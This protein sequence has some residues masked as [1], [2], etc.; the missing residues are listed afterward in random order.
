MLVSCVLMFR[1]G[2]RELALDWFVLLE[3][4]QRFTTWRWAV[5]TQKSEKCSQ[6]FNDCEE[7]K[8]SMRHRS[9]NVTD[10]KKNYFFRYDR[11]TILWDLI[12]PLWLEWSYPL[13]GS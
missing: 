11:P 9:L 1:V 10:S 12:Q 8:L 4:N 6:L 13:L 2:W 5:S 3:K 7:N